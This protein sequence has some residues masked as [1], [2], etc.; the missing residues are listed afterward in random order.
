MPDQGRSTRS[1]VIAGAVLVVFV[2]GIAIGQALNDGPP[3]PATETYVRT[4]TTLTEQT[5]TT[6]G[7]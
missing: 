5:G 6:T 4:L 1:H 2:L 3:P 7:S